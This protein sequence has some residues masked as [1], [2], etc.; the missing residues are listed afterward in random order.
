MPNKLTK[1]IFYYSLIVPL[2]TATIFA[3]CFAFASVGTWLI[4]LV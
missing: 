3:I 4:R 1:E 2:I